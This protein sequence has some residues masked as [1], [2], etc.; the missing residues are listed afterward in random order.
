MLNVAGGHDP[1]TW[2][3]SQP[4]MNVRTS[5][6]FNGLQAHFSSESVA[7]HMRRPLWAIAAIMVMVA[8]LPFAAAT[9]SPGQHLLQVQSLAAGCGLK[10]EDTRAPAG[11]PPRPAIHGRGQ[12]CIKTV[13]RAC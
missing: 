9:V 7:N 8:L 2:Q 6:F 1:V 11:R 3:Q 12:A 13:R 10:G 4:P 5:A